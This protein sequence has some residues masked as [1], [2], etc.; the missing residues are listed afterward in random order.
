MDPFFGLNVILMFE[1]KKR[2]AGFPAP[3]GSLRSQFPI[4]F[5]EFAVFNVP[6]LFHQFD[7]LIGRKRAQLD[8]V[9]VHGKDISRKPEGRN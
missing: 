3:P 1:V 4:K 8:F 2:G 9:F 6:L 5:L 7:L